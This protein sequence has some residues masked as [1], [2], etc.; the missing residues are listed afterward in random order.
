VTK[1]LSTL[2]SAPFLP[3]YQAAGVAG[4]HGPVEVVNQELDGVG[5]RRIR[6]RGMRMS[7]E[8]ADLPGTHAN[9]HGGNT[10]RFQFHL[11]WICSLSNLAPN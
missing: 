9:L 8:T 6:L 10:R 7:T 2:P 3:F 4:G 1:L 11:V 5:L